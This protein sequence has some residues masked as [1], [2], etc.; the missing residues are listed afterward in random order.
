MTDTVFALT[1]LLYPLGQI[2]STV[3]YMFI[4]ISEAIYLELTLCRL[5]VHGA[6]APCGGAGT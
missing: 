5:V 2:S 3:M 6:A 4:L 1:E